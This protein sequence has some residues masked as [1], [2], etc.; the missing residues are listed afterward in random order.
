MAAIAA[1]IA[2]RTGRSVDLILTPLDA[3][4][5]P[6]RYFTTNIPH[7]NLLHIGFN[8]MWIWSLG[9]AIESRL[10]PLRMMG[11][12]LLTGIVSSAAELLLLHTSIGLSGIV[13]GFAAFA[14]MR[15]RHDS[16]F[17]D[18]IDRPMM[19]FFVVWFLFCIIATETGFMPVANAAH[20]GGAIAGGLL[21]MRRP[22]LAP[23]F[24]AA[25]AAGVVLRVGDGG[26]SAKS[27]VLHKRAEAA[28]DAGEYEEAMSLYQS[29]FENGDKTAGAV[30]NYGLSLHRLGRFEE[31]MD[32][33]I[34]AYELDPQVI[35]D[36][37]LRRLVIDEKVA[38]D[39]RR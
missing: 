28:I 39:E 32:A 37:E 34:E 18:V 13:Y 29:L 31:G 27:W 6:W 14:W 2:E 20:A 19:Q 10:S 4:T 21:G 9:S 1:F 25:L 33:F 26:G 24:F 8:L 5:E 30:Y 12:V 17:R 22:W 23:A 11:L 16:R 15:R 3:Y 36:V 35:Q 38:R 7:A